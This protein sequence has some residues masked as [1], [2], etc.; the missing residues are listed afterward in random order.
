M[1]I[2]FRKRTGN[3]SMGIEFFWT[4]TIDAKSPTLIT[5]YIIPELFF[6]YFFIKK[7]K[8]TSVDKIRSSKSLLPRQ[9]LKTIH[10]NPLT[11]VLSAPLILF[12]ARFSLRFAELFWG[13]DLH[14]N[15]LLKQ[16][17]V[18]QNTDDL[19]SLNHRSPVHTRTSRSKNTNLLR[20][21]SKSPAG[22]QFSERQNGDYKNCI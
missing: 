16:R 8:V 4:L 14:S 12:G 9:V 18:D 11:F 15:S 13:G 19:V 20:L 5:D 1:K 22:C 6:D 21:N 10:T 17:W 2:L 7:G 3:P